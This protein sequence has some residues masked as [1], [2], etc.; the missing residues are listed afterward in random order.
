MPQ[1]SKLIGSRNDWRE[2]AVQRAEENRELRKVLAKNKKRINALKAQLK[3]QAHTADDTQK[4]ETY[5]QLNRT[6]SFP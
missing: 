2:K 6:A 1:M 5:S 4:N 3:E